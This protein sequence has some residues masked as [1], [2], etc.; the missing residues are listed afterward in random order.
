MARPDVARVGAPAGLDP[1]AR[2]ARAERD[3]I[4][5]AGSDR[6]VET[7]APELQPP[8][9]PLAPA[10]LARTVDRALGRVVLPT[11]LELAD[12]LDDAAAVLVGDARLEPGLRDV[13]GA[14]LDDERHKV[15]RYVDLRDA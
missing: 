10:G 6:I 12:A 5:R 15:L 3:S 2:I 13:I 9:R 8:T 1:I 11:L 4:A 14:V 7:G